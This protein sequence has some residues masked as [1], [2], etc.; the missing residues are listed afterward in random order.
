MKYTIE[1]HD[2]IRYEHDVAIFTAIA[3]IGNASFTVTQRI[4]Q[5]DSLRATGRT[6]LVHFDYRNRKAAPIPEDIRARLQEMAEA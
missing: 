1:F 3:E 4:M 2:E 5:N 6:T